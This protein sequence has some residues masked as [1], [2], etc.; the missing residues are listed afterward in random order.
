MGLSSSFQTPHQ[1]ANGHMIL[2]FSHQNPGRIGDLEGKSLL[3]SQQSL[4]FDS[5]K[6]SHFPE[7][8]LFLPSSL[9]RFCFLKSSLANWKAASSSEHKHT[10]QPTNPAIT[11]LCALA[12]RFAGPPYLQASKSRGETHD[13]P[14]CKFHST[15]GS[16]T[17]H[18]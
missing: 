9:C 1:T 8:H 2:I 16:R 11:N 18:L 12:Y 6:L 17:S 14:I 7:T 15:Q 10:H 13:H 3:T 5:F 4:D